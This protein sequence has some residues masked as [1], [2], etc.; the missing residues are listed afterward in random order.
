LRTKFAQLSGSFTKT[1]KNFAILLICYVSDV[2]LVYCLYNAV[3][4][5]FYTKQLSYVS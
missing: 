4:L 3:L 1:V 2:L 5:F